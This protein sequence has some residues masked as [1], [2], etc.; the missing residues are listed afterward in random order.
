MST[1][2]QHSAERLAKSEE[3]RARATGFGTTRQGQALLKYRPQLADRIGADRALGRRDKA[4]WGAL[5][6]L[7][8]DDL[9]L[10]LIVAG[11][12][13]CGSDG[14]GVD[15][16]GEKNF[17]DIALWIGRNLSQTRDTAIRFKAGAWGVNML[18]A[19]PV[20]EL[21]GD[22]LTPTDAVHDIMDEALARAVRSNPFLSPL[23][24][25]P[26]PWSQVRTGGL[27]P[28]HW[29]R[30]PL[31]REHG[32][33]IEEA[34]RKAIGTGRMQPVLDAINSLQ[35]VPFTI[36][37]PVLDFMERADDIPELDAVIA[38]AL[39][40]Y[41][42]FY[43][44]LNIDFRG[45]IYGASHFN[46]Q[47]EDHVRALFLFADG[48]PIGEDG[49]LWLKAHVA[50]RADGN[51]WSS[52]ARPSDLDRAGRIKWTE[53]NLDLLR[54]IGNAVL[55]R[56]DPASI[57]WALPKDK[58]QFL[59]ACAELVQALDTGP[60]FITKLPLTFDGSCSGLQHLCAMTRAEEGR[61][62]NLTAGN[63]ADDLYRRVAFRA[64][65]F[66]RATVKRP[67]MS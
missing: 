10:R 27:P 11:V 62:V 42:R 41:D 21:K 14:L 51:E 35:R 33:S 50:A 67:A 60:E 6:G 26:E 29:A 4:V 44:P 63:E 55:S 39:T 25:P 31:I 64:N 13:V 47:R 53:D 59:A 23:A 32:R 38:A 20:F 34:A 5:R 28:D 9:A 37:L 2:L 48:E 19:L 24:E 12:S 7:S 65:W 58:Y 8:D 46:F 40:L 17:R 61:F 45:R 54:K 43:V 49:L 36:N 30:V 3:Y 22:I 57:A 56:G 18:A 52:A 16:D 15:D 66:D 1:D